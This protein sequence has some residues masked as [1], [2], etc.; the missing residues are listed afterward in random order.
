MARTGQAV[1]QDH[2]APKHR[3]SAEPARE[4]LE[5]IQWVR[6]GRA[7]RPQRRPQRRAE[8]CKPMGREERQTAWEPTAPV[9]ARAR[10]LAVAQ[11]P[12]QRP[13][14]PH[15]L[16]HL[17]PCHPPVPQPQRLQDSGRLG[18]QRAKH[19]RP[20]TQPWPRRRRQG[21]HRRSRLQP[22]RRRREQP[23]NP[24]AV[25]RWAET[26][27][28]L[29]GWHPR[30]ETTRGREWSP[31]HRVPQPEVAAK[32]PEEGRAQAAAS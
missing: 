27:H 31:G 21:L 30:R 26:R 19:V 18:Y 13:Q 17:A 14:L 8:E 2:T 10:D 5:R 15:R 24:R 12:K 32:I 1:G 25:H 29:R 16:D 7:P 22:G 28:Q 11:L 20:W 23:P 3:P 4:P 9:Q 6:R